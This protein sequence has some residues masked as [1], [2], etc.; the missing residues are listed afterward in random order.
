VSRILGVVGSPRRGGN[1]DILVSEILGSAAAAG[2]VTE[3]IY[4]ADLTINEC[5]GCHAC[6][7]GRDC[8]MFDDMNPLHQKIAESDLLV[9]GTPVYWYGPT[10]LIKCFVD[11]LVFFNCPENRAK[12]KGKKAVLAI[13]FEEEDPAVAGLTVSL[14]EKTL[15]Y[16]EMGL[17]GRVIVPGVSAKGEVKNK[18]EA[19]ESCRKLGRK[20]A[21]S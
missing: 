5:D 21:A 3:T 17:A 16:L 4:L 12:I 15:D 2:A 10:A 14:F 1:T 13:P 7:T 20:L 19:L 6:W 11:R 8:T 18:S 9:L